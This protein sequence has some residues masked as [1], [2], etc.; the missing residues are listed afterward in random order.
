MTGWYS[1]HTTGFTLPI[2]LELNFYSRSILLGDIPLTGKIDKIEESPSQ[3]ITGKT[4]VSLIDYKTGRTK[5]LNEIKG[6][7][8]NSEGNY[9][10][11]LLFYKIMFDLDAELMKK[12]EVSDLAI[13][14]V[15]G[16]DGKY[17]HIAVDY[18]PE[19]VEGVKALIAEV[20]GKMNDMEFWRNLLKK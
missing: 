2:E 6:N 1:I 9:F 5:S 8:A 13:E 3:A 7:T 17:A 14:F 20:W 12:Y 4:P 18:T 15:E 16:K 11:Q 10:R 19:D